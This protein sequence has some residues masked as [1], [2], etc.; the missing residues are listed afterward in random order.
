MIELY[1]R[2]KVKKNGFPGNIVSIDDNHGKDNPIYY[3][4]IDD[5]Y[6]VGDFSKDMIWCERDEIELVEKFD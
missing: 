4:E 5:E 1:D 6:K 2:V 3:V